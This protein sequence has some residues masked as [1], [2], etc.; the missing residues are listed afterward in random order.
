M[1]NKIVDIPGNPNYYLKGIRLKNGKTCVYW[2]NRSVKRINEV[3][4]IMD[5]KNVAAIN[6]N[7]ICI[8]L[9]GIEDINSQKDCLR[10]FC[11]QLRGMGLNIKDIRFKFIVSDKKE[12]QLV[13]NMISSLGLNGEIINGI[14]RGMNPKRGIAT[15]NNGKDVKN[16]DQ[17]KKIEK[18]IED[19]FSN[20]H[21]EGIGGSDI[22]VVSNGSQQYIVNGDNVAYNVTNDGLTA[23]EMMK[24]KYNELKDNPYERERLSSMSDEEKIK[25]AASK[26]TMGKK[27]N[28][29]EGNINSDDNDSYRR[30]TSKLVNAND[31]KGNS[32][33][34]IVVDKNKEEDISVVERVG[35][36]NARVVQSS[37]SKIGVNGSFNEGVRNERF[38]QQ[39]EKEKE[40][41]GLYYIGDDNKIYDDKGQPVEGASYDVENNVLLNGESIGVVNGR[42]KD[43]DVSSSNKSKSGDTFKREIA[44]PAINKKLVKKPNRNAAFISLP[45]IMFIISLLLLV[46]SGIIWFM[47]K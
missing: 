2:T 34:G 15:D 24:N 30:V 18:K 45:V 41:L 39:E 16:K 11:V 38:V 31:A 10:A 8:S 47:T 33:I 14:N 22:S 5:N 26:V 27:E 37:S 46:G 12:V 28:Y 13:N 40:V 29:L 19:K 6:D 23:S 36:N 25:Y 3:V 35:D 20:N 17:E 21:R 1:D 43:L 7:Q 42:L 4:V 44:S 9:N 32:E